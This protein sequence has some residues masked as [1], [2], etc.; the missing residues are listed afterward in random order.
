MIL[1]LFPL[2]VSLRTTK[3]CYSDSSSLGDKLHLG[4]VFHFVLFCFSKTED[5]VGSNREPRCLVGHGWILLSL[6]VRVSHSLVADCILMF[7][8]RGSKAVTKFCVTV[9]MSQR[10]W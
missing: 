7:E 4:W 1:D 6:K 5:V 10:N 2:K 3:C 8:G 9:N